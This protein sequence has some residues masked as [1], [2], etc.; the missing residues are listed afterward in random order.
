MDAD[1]ISYPLRLQKQVAFLQS[2]PEVD[3]VGAWASVFKGD[4]M[5]LGARRAP[6]EHAAICARPYGISDGASHLMGRTNGFVQPLQRR[7]GAHG[8]TELLVRTYEHS[9]F[10]VMP[11]VMLGYRE[12]SLSEEAI[13]CEK[14]MCGM[15]ISYGFRSQKGSFLLQ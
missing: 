12:D 1:D 14:N 10:A 3:L 8:V 5:L 6:I 2:H 13:Y 9:R 4:G 11:E 15:A 7:C